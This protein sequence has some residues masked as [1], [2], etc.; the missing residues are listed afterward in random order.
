M[1][2]PETRIVPK[3]SGVLDLEV[4]QKKLGAKTNKNKI[5]YKPG[6]GNARYAYVSWAYVAQRLNDAYGEGC[7]SREILS[8][9]TQPFNEN[10]K[11]GVEIIVKC[12]I[13]TPTG[14]SDAYGSAKYYS[15]NPMGSYGN[16]AQSALSVATRRAAAPMGIGLDLY[17]KEDLDEDLVSEDILDAKAAYKSFIRTIG[18]NEISALSILKSHY[19]VANATNPGDI[20]NSIQGKTEPE[21]VWEMISVIGKA[22]Q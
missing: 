14:F 2:N 6:S 13:I 20:I 5:K 10:G 3:T 12:R 17:A 21:A 11:T 18:I 19:Q 1:D 4:T 9:T 8:E 7:W 16:S 15:N 22:V